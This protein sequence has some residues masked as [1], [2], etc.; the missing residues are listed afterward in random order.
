MGKQAFVS[1]I[2]LTGEE[3]ALVQVAGG[4]HAHQRGHGSDPLGGAD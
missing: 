4:R 3:G 1:K 2:A